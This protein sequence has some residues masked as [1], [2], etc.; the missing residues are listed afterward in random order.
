MDRSNAGSDNE[1]YIMRQPKII[2]WIGVISAL[3][4]FIPFIIFAIVG[5]EDFGPF[6]IS[7]FSLFIG[8]GV[9]LAVYAAKW[10]IIVEKDV[11]NVFIPFRQA[12]ALTLKDITSVKQKHNGIVIYTGE[13]P[14]FA[15][16]NIVTGFDVFCSQLYEAGK[17][18]ATQ[19]RDSFAVRQHKGNILGGIFG[20][21]FGAGM[22]V[23][24]FIQTDSFASYDGETVVAMLFFATFAACSLFFAISSFSWRLTVSG[25]TLTVKRVF[26]NEKEY[27]IRDITKV[28]VGKEKI[29]LHID[30]KKIV[31]VAVGC[32]GFPILI[33]RL[34]S[35]KIPFYYKG[36]IIERRQ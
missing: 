21:L 23:F 27:N 25:S 8:L 12:R 31:K 14:A 4:F 35:E 36:K 13:K 24:S 1:N 28:S 33:E 19:C 15:V 2:F 9:F 3:I 7:G 18:E 32:G 6:V 30:D 20:F 26:R 22:V 5:S 16:D 10:K 29:T 17:M 34:D 11:Y